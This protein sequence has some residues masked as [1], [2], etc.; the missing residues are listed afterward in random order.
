MN[1]LMISI[2]YPPVP[3]GISAHVYELSKALA[4][5]GHRVSVVTR[6]RTGQPQRSAAD[7]WEV[8]R[9]PL[10]YMALVYGLQLRSFVRKLL[11]ELSPD[12][13][14]IHGMGP[15]EWYNID[16][17][18]LAYTN[19]TSGYLKRIQKGGWRRMAMLKRHFRK[20]DLFLAPSRELLHVPFTFPAPK[21]FIANGVDAGKFSRN[22]EMRR[23]I[24][25]NLGIGEEE[26]V[27]VVTRR[28]VDKNGVL[29]LARAT[30]ILKTTDPGIRFIVI[31]DGPERTAV[32]KEFN[33]HC[34]S[35]AIFLGS[36]THEEIVDYYSAADFS[37]LPSL[38]EATS[39]SGL[40]AMAAGLPL[41]G[42]DVGGIP[43]LIRNG[44]NGYLCRPADP[45]DLADKIH[46]LLGRDFREMGKKSREMVDEQFD[47]QQ[48][49]RQTLDSYRQVLKKD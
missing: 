22:N 14:H 10:K 31:G 36:K 5:A 27:A 45:Q 33:R 19:H 47:W 37:I 18:P 13:I 32:E 12:I 44:V 48:I 43:E 24:R 26:I 40:E 21:R 6:R 29:Y 20:V 34:G 28:L 1:I 35:R 9:V 41:V 23:T 25:R 7:G 17:I 15:L 16:H 8:Y 3:G 2:D 30:E 4:K 11:P 46:T 38:M 42:T 49:A 39:I